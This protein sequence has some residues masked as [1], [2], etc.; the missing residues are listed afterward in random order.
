MYDVNKIHA[1]NKE[2]MAKI[3]YTFDIIIIVSYIFL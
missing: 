3:L 2:L 1:L